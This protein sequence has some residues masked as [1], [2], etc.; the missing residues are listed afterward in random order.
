MK[1]HFKSILLCAI[2]ILIVLALWHY[3]K[4]KESKLPSESTNSTINVFATQNTA[5]L[6]KDKQKT[7]ISGSMEAKLATPSMIQTN[8]QTLVGKARIMVENQNAKIDFWGL[9]EDQDE[10]P[11]EGAKIVGNT[12]TWH[13]TASLGI[14][15]IFPKISAITGPNGK[16]EIHDASGDVLS[17]E[18][19]QK[20]G[21]ELESNA[22][23]DFG[24]R[25]SERFSADPNNPIIFRMWKTNIHEHLISG[26][27]TFDVVPDGRPYFINLTSDTISESGTGDLKVWI[28]YTNQ[29]VRGQLYDWSAGIEVVNGG[30]L[31]DTGRYSSMYLAPTGGFTPSFQLR[32]Q[33]KGGQSGEIGDRRFYLWLK[34][35]QEYGRMNINLYAP[36]GYLSPGL[37]RISYA[38]NPSG[39]R[40]LKP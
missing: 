10:N 37:I 33:I 28:Q 12:R 11:I 27:K 7:N 24:Y 14:D 35:G 15:T 8:L 34:N 30:L 2:A 20:D 40:I 36:Y 39:S 16:F 5:E 29:V 1:N 17:V 21:Y 31:E 18:S 3:R 26:G 19:V 6:D 38:V 9:V 4:E 32:Q 25:T 23:R 22:Q 13:V